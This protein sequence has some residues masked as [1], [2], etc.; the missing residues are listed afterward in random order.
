MRKIICVVAY[1]NYIYAPGHE[2]IQLDTFSKLWMIA[3]SG[4][5]SHQC[6]DK[7]LLYFYMKNYEVNYYFSQLQTTLR[8]PIPCWF[9]IPKHF[10]VG[11]H[12]LSH[13]RFRWNS[14]P[15]SLSPETEVTRSSLG[16][17][18]YLQFWWTCIK[19][20]HDPQ[21]HKPSN[22]HLQA[23]TC[24]FWEDSLEDQLPQIVSWLHANGN[25]YK[26]QNMTKLRKLV[27]SSK[28]K[29]IGDP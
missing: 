18:L 29:K 4:I 17:C 10:P 26:A 19:I 8:F 22:P 13:I 11:Q 21:Q 24:Q 2:V 16:Q 14:L 5:V 12:F 6:K 23:E 15:R 9:L 20:H 7:L 25:F 1:P 3:K 28:E 27:Y